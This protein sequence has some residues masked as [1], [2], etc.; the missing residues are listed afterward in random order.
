M[1]PCEGRCLAAAPRC[2]MRRNPVRRHT[3]RRHTASV[4]RSHLAHPELLW[5]LAD[6][7]HDALASGT[8]E[9]MVGGRVE[10]HQIVDQLAECVTV[11]CAVL[12]ALKHPCN[13]CHGGLCRRHLGR[14]GPRRSG[15]GHRDDPRGVRR[16]SHRPKVAERSRT[17]PPPDAPGLDR[18]AAWGRGTRGRRCPRAREVRRL[19]LPR[20]PVV[21]PREPHATPR[22]ISSRRTLWAVPR[23]L[24][25]MWDARGELTADAIRRGPCVVGTNFGRRSSSSVAASG[26]VLDRRHERSQHPQTP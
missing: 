6:R 8:V 21:R 23:L 16:L 13:L 17:C 19:R 22:R 14:C 10:A 18:T 9:L 15:R 5:V 24:R 12:E 26:A 3:V 1:A 4:G 2:P 7:V 20:T 25:G 11:D